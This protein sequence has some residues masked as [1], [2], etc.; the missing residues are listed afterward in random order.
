MIDFQTL[1]TFIQTNTLAHGHYTHFLPKEDV[2]LKKVLQEALSSDAN[3]GY[4]DGEPLSAL[5]FIA[6]LEGGQRVDVI[7]PFF[8]LDNLPSATRIIQS[9]L[10]DYPNATL[11]FFF[12]KD[13]T[14]M[15]SLM[16]AMNAKR[17]DDEFILHLSKTTDL[18]VSNERL[19]PLPKHHEEAVWNLHTHVFGQTYLTK[20]NFFN[21]TQR[22]A[23]GYYH[24]GTLIGYGLLNRVS[25]TTTSI[26]VL[27]IDANYRGQ[28]HGRKL[29]EELISMAFQERPIKRIELVVESLN[30]N[31]LS[32]YKSVG[33][34]IL[35]HSLNYTLKK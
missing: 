15:Q 8:S 22:T 6:P 33:F 10:H 2:R 25:L 11:H 1:Y 23:Y 19:V 27:A 35:S 4:F 18:P 14:P 20:E 30:N 21:D 28:N 34:T 5:A 26:E 7:G 17:H 29:L 3:Q 16:N 31:A 13:N 32:L 24:N 9:I 12:P